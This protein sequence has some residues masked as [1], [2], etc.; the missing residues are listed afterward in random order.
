MRLA[1]NNPD[2]ALGFED[3]VW[4]SREAQPQMHAWSEG[5]PLRLLEKHVA[6]KDPD[7]KAIAC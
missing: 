3:E 7:A 2:I 1:E 5:D 4:W 6:P